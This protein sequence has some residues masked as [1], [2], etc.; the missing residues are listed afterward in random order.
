MHGLVEPRTPP[1]GVRRPGAAPGRHRNRSRRHSTFA[2][3]PAIGRTRIF[4][5]YQWVEAGPEPGQTP[6]LAC[7]VSPHPLSDYTP[8]MRAAPAAIWGWTHDP[9]KQALG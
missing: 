4:R 5:G 6:V 7:V 3:A 1:K 8:R 2:L 9:Q